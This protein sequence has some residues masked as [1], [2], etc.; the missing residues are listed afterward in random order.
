MEFDLLDLIFAKAGAYT[1]F[2]F[3][4]FYPDKRIH[5]FFYESKRIHAG[6]Y[7]RR[8]NKWCNVLSFVFFALFDNHLAGKLPAKL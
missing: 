4:F 2:R 5:R 6:I 3:L 7:R 8:F 1:R